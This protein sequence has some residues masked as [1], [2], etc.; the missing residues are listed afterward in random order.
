MHAKGVK[1]HLLKKDAE[2]RGILDN[3]ISKLELIDY[4]QFIDLLFLKDQRVINL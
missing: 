2:K 3:L 1:F 4:D